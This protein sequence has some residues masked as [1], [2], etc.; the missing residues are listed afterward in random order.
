MELKKVIIVVSQYNERLSK[1][2]PWYSIK[3]LS[4]DFKAND[5]NVEII[6][7]INQIPYE[8][9]GVVIKVWSLKDIFSKVKNNVNYRLFYLFTFPLYPLSKILDLKYSDI[10]K[11]FDPLKRII[12]ASLIPKNIIKKNLNKAENIITISDRSYLYLKKN[13]IVS[14]QYFPFEYDNWGGVEL[15][16]NKNKSKKTIGYFGP[17]YSTRG[18]V[19]CLHFF[20]FID[21]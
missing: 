6:N 14:I 10:R 18:F 12:L 11:N 9:S 7:S 20:K 4:N 2:Q 5:I 15:L 17:P 16:K 13:N 1:M 21:I 19:Q 3:K 8:F